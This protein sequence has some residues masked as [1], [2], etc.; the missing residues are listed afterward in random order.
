VLVTRPSAF[1]TGYEGLRARDVTLAD[2]SRLRLVESGEP[3]APPLLLVHGFGA[4]SYQWRFQLPALAAAGFHVLAPDLPG[5]GFS[6]LRFPAGEYTRTAY[7]RRIWQLVDAL[8]VTRLPVVGQSMGGGIVAEM[9]WQQPDRP[10]GLVLMS[11]VGFG[12]VPARARTLL[13]VPD[14]LAP[15]GRAFATHAV[16]RFILSGVYG[17]ESSWTRRDEDELL[18]PYGQ[19]EIF[20]ALLRTLKEFDFTLHTPERLAALPRGTLVMFGAE[21]RVVRPVALADRVRAM[22]DGRIVVLPRVGHL[23]QVEAADEVA[24]L[25]MEYVRTRRVAPANAAR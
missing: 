16:V 23:P 11:A 7:A 4:S 3:H 2:G 13:P 5:H 6:Q 9:A 1:P 18:A 20:R 24:R 15:L 10:D 19:S 25:L 21:D 8:G 22:R 17:R 12:E 14:V